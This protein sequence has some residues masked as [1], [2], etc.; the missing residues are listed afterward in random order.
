LFTRT[1]RYRKVTDVPIQ[2]DT[3]TPIDEE[4]DED[5]QP[6]TMIPKIVKTA[7]SPLSEQPPE[8]SKLLQ[9]PSHNTAKKSSESLSKSEK[10]TQNSK[11]KEIS[12]M[13]SVL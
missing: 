1:F 3:L 4:P 7:A 5:D 2:I 11:D 10:D 6:I 12:Q 9:A 13:E 8:A